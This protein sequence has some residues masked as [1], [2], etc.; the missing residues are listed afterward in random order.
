MCDETDS[1]SVQEPSTWGQRLTRWIPSEILYL[2]RR[3]SVPQLRSTTAQA[4]QAKW[5]QDGSDIRV[6]VFIQMPY[7]PLRTGEDRADCVG[8][9]EVVIGT[10]DLRYRDP[11]PS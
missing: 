5:L 2:F 11:D 8:F 10:T 3:P 4:V 9:H 6:S 7:S 1:Q